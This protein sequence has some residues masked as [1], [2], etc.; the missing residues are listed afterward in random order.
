MAARSGR[1]Q[2]PRAAEEVDERA[3]R[4][5]ERRRIAARAPRGA[6]AG[7]RAA[8]ASPARG[9]SARPAGAG[10]L[11]RRRPRRRAVPQ[12]TSPE[13][14]SASSSAALVAGH[15]RGEDLALP[16]PGR[17]VEALQ[18]P[19]HL[20]DARERRGAA[21]PGATC[22][23]RSRKRT[24][25]AAETGSIS[26]RSRASVSRWMR[27]SRLRSHQWGSSADQASPAR[28]R[29]RRTSPSDSSRASAAWTRAGKPDARGERGPGER[30]AARHPSSDDRERRRVIVGGDALGGEGP[31]L[32]I[33]RRGPFDVAP[34]AAALRSG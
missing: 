6:R 21:R 4:G 24:R 20:G 30:P 3:G 1:K 13:R 23:Q 22:C 10:A 19:D 25:S 5:A 9:G 29:P 31:E 34:P 7:R 18:L 33:E 14:Q 16:G 2:A 12:A 15:A 28:K 27:A 26:R 32:G 8:P 11:L 17:G